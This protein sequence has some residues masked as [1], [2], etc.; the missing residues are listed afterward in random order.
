MKLSHLSLSFIAAVGFYNIAS[1]T[2]PGHSAPHWEY[3]GEAGAANW[4][5]LDESF[6]L[7]EGGQA[8]SPVDIKESIDADLPAISFAYKPFFPKI[9]N[10]GH[11]IQ[12]NVTEGSSIQV[13]RDTYQLLQ[14][15]FHTPSEYQINSNSYPL[16]VHFVHKRAD[17]ALGVVGVMFAEGEANAELEKIWKNIPA[18]AGEENNDSK[19]P[20]DITKLLPAD[21][22]YYR[23][24]GSLTTPPCSEGVNWHVMQQP[25]S[26]S[27]E[28]IEAFRKLY[29]M[30]ARPLQASNNRL[31]VKDDK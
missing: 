21:Q 25:I 14:F 17:G 28:Q 15:H 8:Q 4:S 20:T 3:E 10:N 12:V 6:R 19:L 9:I 26:A 27:K 18:N 2:E 24:M 23:F 5:G 30:N 13:G 31:I 11:T 7:C 1:A 29:P 16:E 22:K